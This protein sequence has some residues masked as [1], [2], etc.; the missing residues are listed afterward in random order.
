[1]VPLLVELTIGEVKLDE[2]LKA[3]EWDPGW[4]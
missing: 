3:M 2:A 4:D 1:M